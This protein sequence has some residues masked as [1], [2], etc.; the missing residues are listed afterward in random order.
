MYMYNNNVSKDTEASRR[1]TPRLPTSQGT[2]RITYTPSNSLT[3]IASPYV[4]L[5]NIASQNIRMDRPSVD[6]LL[7]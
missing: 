3:S 4:R 2:C 5:P 1:I 7:Y 6:C